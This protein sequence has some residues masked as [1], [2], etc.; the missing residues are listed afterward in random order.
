METNDERRFEVRRELRRVR[1]ARLLVF[2]LLVSATSA[3]FG[4]RIMEEPLG[5][6]VLVAVLE[7]VAR[8]IH[9]S[10][11]PVARFDEHGVTYAEGW[12]TRRV[13]FADV[14]SWEAEREGRAVIF[15][16]H[17]GATYPIWLREVASTDRK[18]ILT[19]LEARLPPASI[20]EHIEPIV[21]G[22]VALVELAAFA[23]LVLA[24]M[25]VLTWFPRRDLA[26]TPVPAPVVSLWPDVKPRLSRPPA[27]PP[28]GPF[29]GAYAAPFHPETMPLALQPCYGGPW[30][31][32]SSIATSTLL[33][34]IKG[35]FSSAVRVFRG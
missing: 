11:R 20:R 12:R 7:R 25:P 30:G 6:L 17:D 5:A 1:L 28:Y 22:R 10:R 15:T 27:T 14:M 32:P 26:R 2:G 18:R 3:M 24:T 34:A 31:D 8:E 4:S 9:D 16:T 13:A 21:P 29:V 23:V 33:L 19:Y 35:C